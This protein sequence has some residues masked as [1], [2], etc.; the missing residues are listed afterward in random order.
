MGIQ[1]GG[2]D[3][4]KSGVGKGFGGKREKK[5]R[6]YRREKGSL[7]KGG[8]MYGF[9][10]QGGADAK[11]CVAAEP[12]G[13]TKEDR[14]ANTRNLGGTL[15]RKK[16]EDRKKGWE[17]ISRE[18]SIHTPRR[19]RESVGKEVWEPGKLVRITA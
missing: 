9:R 18:K 19:G 12:R 7:K 10:C 11:K 6:I 15:C 16:I 3:L 8:E 17:A 1:W 13:T 4:H 14:K 5:K 2:G